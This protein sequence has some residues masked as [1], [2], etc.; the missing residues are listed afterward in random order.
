[1]RNVEDYVPSEI[2]RLSMSEFAG[3]LYERGKDRRED[4]SEDYN[5][6]I[7]FQKSVHEVNYLLEEFASNS[8]TLKDVTEDVMRYVFEKLK[9]KC[10]LVDY[11]NLLLL[12]LWN[13]EKKLEENAPASRPLIVN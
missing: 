1:M 4:L 8:E 3:K 5:L 6:V 12:Q 10:G 7:D 11:E 2:G 9:E 13:I